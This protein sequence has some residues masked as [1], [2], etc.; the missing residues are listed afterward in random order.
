M[1]ARVLS[2]T[3]TNGGAT[4]GNFAVVGYD[5]YGNLMHETIV[6]AAAATTAYGLK[7]WKYIVSVTP[8]FT[9]TQTYSVGT[10]DV[11]GLPIFSGFFEDTELS[12]IAAWLTANTG[13]LAG[14]LTA[15]TAAT[16]DVR[17]TIQL[18]TAG[19][20]TGYTTSPDAAKR[21]KV[22]Q[23]IPTWMQLGSTYLNPEL[24]FGQPQ[25]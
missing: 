7:A 5:M 4:G 25:F 12:W 17:G 11:F 16:G 2:I 20:G 9:D 14:V 23:E 6:Q 13:W 10:G 19:G 1:A 24:M 3:A 21:L 18:G 22:Y 8:D 15:P